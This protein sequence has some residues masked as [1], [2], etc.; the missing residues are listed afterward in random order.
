MKKLIKA[1]GNLFL[2]EKPENSL[3]WEEL[4]AWE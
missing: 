2:G 4:G 1:I 3:T